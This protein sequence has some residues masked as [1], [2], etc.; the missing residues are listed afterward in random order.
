MC[1]NIHITVRIYV[2]LYAKPTDSDNTFECYSRN[3]YVNK[4]PYI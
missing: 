4:S 3:V 2:F 1:D